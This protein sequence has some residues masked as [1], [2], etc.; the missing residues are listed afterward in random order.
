MYPK[1]TT[2][3]SVPPDHNGTAT[4]PGVAGIGIDFS[5][6]GDH[7]VTLVDNVRDQNF[8]DFPKNQSYVAGFFAPLFNQLTDRNV[9]TVDAYDWAHRTGANPPND[10]SPDL[11]R[12]RPAHPFLYESTFGHEWQHLLESY[13]DP[14]ETTWVNE[15]LSMF[16]EALDG[17]TDTRRNI[18][19]PAAQPQLLCFQGWGTV[20]GPSNPNPHACGGPQNSLTMWGDEG[21]GSEILSDYGNTWSFMLY[22]FDRFG[23]GFMTG[24]HRDG[25]NQGLDGVQAELDKYAPGMKVAT[26]LRQ[27]QLMNLVDHYAKN[28]KVT[29]I[30]RA[31]VTAKDLDATLNL[32][33]PASYDLPGAAPNGA[34]Y[35]RLREGTRM[36]TGAQLHSLD[37]TGEKTVIPSANDPNDPTSGLSGSSGGAGAVAGWYVS[38]VGIDPKGNRVL[39]RSHDGFSWKPDDRT[40]AEFRSYPQV[41]AV[42]AHDDPT[43]N[44]PGTEGY[45]HYTLKANGNSQ[46]GG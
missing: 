40:L 32:D 1:E 22:C 18:S 41:V 21:Q 29:G 2:A 9:M 45:A 28:G 20:K 38:L 39:I 17:Y 44:D 30:D 8:Y 13:Q 6:D 16:A 7:T 33:N 15:G 31:L 26:L 14:N 46:P 19:Q 23:L 36:L 34:D 11:C 42:V 12:S 5:G 4:V 43:D 35:V 27:F 37:F 3:F 25:K 24:L 10:P